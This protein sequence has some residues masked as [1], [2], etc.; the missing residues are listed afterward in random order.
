LKNFLILKLP[1]GCIFSIFNQT[2]RPANLKDLEAHNLRRK[3]TV[4]GRKK[5]N[6][7]R[8]IIFEKENA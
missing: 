3:K 4:L 1:P 7:R 5:H 2:R 6:L 8:K